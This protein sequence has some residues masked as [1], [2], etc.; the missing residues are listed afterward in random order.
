MVGK[1]CGC[2]C[3]APAELENHPGGKGFGHM[4]SECVRIVR[5]RDCEEKH[6][7]SHCCDI[8]Q[9]AWHDPGV[10]PVIPKKL[11]RMTIA[12]GSAS[13]AAV[14]AGDSEDAASQSNSDS[15]VDADAHDFTADG[16][17]PEALTSLHTVKTASERA[18]QLASDF[19]QVSSIVG[20]ADINGR[21]PKSLHFL[22]Q[23]DAAGDC[24]TTAAMLLIPT[25]D[26]PGVNMASLAES[27]AL[28]SGSYTDVPV[29]AEWIKVSRK[30]AMQSKRA[31][32]EKGM[33]DTSDAAAVGAFGSR[34][35][36]NKIARGQLGTGL[37]QVWMQDIIKHC[38]AKA[39]FV[40]D[41]A[42]GVGEIMKAAINCKVA[43]AATTTGVRVCTW[44][45]DPR[46][47]FA[48]IG[49]A[50]GRTEISK[51]YVSGK[52]VVPGHQP[53]ADPGS[54]PE[55]TRK[56]VK[57]LLQKP[58]KSLSLNS[59][60]HLII[61]TQ[62]EIAKACP[63]TLNEEHERDFASWRIEFPR[64]AAA[65]VGATEVAAT[66]SAD[67]QGSAGGGSGVE[68]ATPPP[69]APGAQADSIAVLKEKFGDEILSQKPLPEGG[70]A[71]TREMTLCL[72]AT[73]AA[74][75]AQ[76]TWRV[77][78][79]N[80]ASKNANV[81]AG[82]CIGQ[83]GQGRFVS[84]VS[85]SI[86]QDKKDFSWRYTRLTGFKKDNAELANG[87]MIFNKAGTPLE[88]KPSCVVLCDVEKEIG[89]NVTLYAHAITRGGAKVTITPSPA[90]VVWLP[91]APAV[92]GEGPGVANFEAATLGQFLRSHE[93][94]TGV[95]K[96]QG[97]ARPVFE[98][99]ASQ[100]PQQGAYA[101]MPVAAP[102]RSALWLFTTKKI[103]VPGK[104]FVFLG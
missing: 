99:K 91:Q 81:P 28:R 43:E 71:A 86:E 97:L 79:H 76:K 30:F 104:G 95:P 66:S 9:V 65:A 35:A 47:I 80:K 5:P 64:I 92:G 21:Y 24:S 93:D 27:Q 52:L 20:M 54:R 42:H 17:L 68:S 101:L 67:P 3:C 39:L 98:M 46:K 37:H 94:T 34:Y 13:A 26:T 25:H 89:N 75:G 32:G 16:V 102:G 22:H 44:G 48:E 55:R 8:G 40:C 73:Q 18:A 63:V 60:G 49:Q 100:A 62:E 4:S 29:P 7:R 88:G 58:M 85:Q 87:F 83:G 84:L 10:F 15:D 1:G 103:E 33:L 6:T 41:F 19:H 82:T 70:A 50:V 11:K 12:E 38:G 31:M 72:T 74:D 90:P 14:G 36:L 77:W 2:Q 59:E 61:P 45:Q 69:L 53:I 57:A 51:L 96:C 78:L 23:A 56:L